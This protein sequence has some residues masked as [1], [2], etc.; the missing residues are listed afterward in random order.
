M[1]EQEILDALEELKI[2][3]ADELADFINIGCAS[4]RSSLN[5]LLRETEVERIELTRE[6]VLSEGIRF[7][8]RHYKWKIKTSRRR[9]N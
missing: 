2:A 9:L 1:S 7:S 6:E 8:G 3:T 5:R 4:V